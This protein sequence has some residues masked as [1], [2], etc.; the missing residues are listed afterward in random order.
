MAITRL[1]TQV[2][3]DGL[4][5]LDLHVADHD[6]RALQAVWRSGRPSL[7][8]E[9]GL[10][11][12]E[13]SFGLIYYLT[14][15]AATVGAGL[16]LLQRCLPLAMPWLQLSIEEQGEEQDEEVLLAFA[17]QPRFPGRDEADLFALGILMRR[18]QRTPVRPVRFTRIDL[19]LRAP[20]DR[21]A[22][23]RLVGGT[24]LRFGARS[25]R[26]A[27]AREDWQL[28]LRRS[29][30]RLTELLQQQLALAD[31]PNAG[32]LT[33]LRA[34]LRER[35]PDVE[36]AAL[37]LG[38]SRRSLQRKLSAAGTTFEQQRD[39][40]RR[41]LAEA[42]LLRSQ[43]SLREV[44][45]RLGF[46][47]QASFTRAFQRWTGSTPSSLRRYGQLKLPSEF[48]AQ[49]PLGTLEQ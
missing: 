48:K 5:R 12:P 6:E 49:W 39:Q 37:A 28:P 19:P 43:L 15:S 31:A 10:H 44:A 16:T 20:A 36:Q 40:V 1:A 45:E 26:M 8:L 3:L 47:E 22:W 38:L 24:P 14:T 29:D 9:V 17:N 35:L 11:T 13:A 33:S 21:E 46:A 2:I 42:L 30:A 4:S 18:L 27:L 25:F 23:R 7:P 32:L 34:L 41:D